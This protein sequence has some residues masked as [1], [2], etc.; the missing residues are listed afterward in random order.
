MSP[1]PHL[2]AL[3][4]AIVPLAIAT[5]ARAERPEP[6]TVDRTVVRFI[7]PET[8]GVLRPRFITQRVLAFEARMLACAEEGR[9]VEPQDR[10]IRAAV[11]QHV[12][13]EML[14][15]LPLEPEPDANALL[16]VATMLRA[17]VADRVGGDDVLERAAKAEGLELREL[18]A[19]F[20][21][22]A[23]AALYVERTITAV[24]YPSDDALRDVY[25]T[26]AHPYRQK[27]YEDARELLER[28]FALERL[29]AMEA[30][31]LQGARSR[32]KITFLD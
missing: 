13:V 4:L 24:L 8:G 10:H 9:L 26:T 5:P 19:A 1:R 18:D 23:R 25:R 21:R 27:R 17:A 31:F 14:V 29:R 15:R 32:V 2:F 22:E 12:A 6:V 30:T 16:R 28:W 7:T 11:E 3:A 20:V